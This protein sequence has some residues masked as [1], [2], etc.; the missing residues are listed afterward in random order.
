MPES[1]QDLEAMVEQVRKLEK[2]RHISP[3]LIRSLLQ[4]ELSKRSHPKEA[5]KATRSKLHQV[6]RLTWKIPP[7]RGMAEYH[8]YL[9]RES[10]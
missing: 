4:S 1:L 7:V 10:G 8:G 5:I 9:A 6:A 3:D 2:Y